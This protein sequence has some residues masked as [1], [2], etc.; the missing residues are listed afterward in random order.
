MGRAMKRISNI[1]FF[2][3]QNIFFYMHHQNKS[4][5]NTKFGGKKFE[6]ARGVYFSNG[7]KPIIFEN[8]LY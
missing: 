5:A 7:Y 2:K 3:F 6:L 4:K 1:F 8:T